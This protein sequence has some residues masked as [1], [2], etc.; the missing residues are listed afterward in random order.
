V[1]TNVP[2]ALRLVKVRFLGNAIVATEAN[3]SGF[4][5]G[6]YLLTNAA[7]SFEGRH[8]EFE[9]NWIDATQFASGGGFYASFGGS[10]AFRLEDVDLTGNDFTGP[11]AI[12]SG[13]AFDFY[14]GGSALPTVR[15]MRVLANGV[16]SGSG[17][18]LVRV[19][20]PSAAAISDLLV[21]DGAGYGLYLDVQCLTCSAVAGNLTVTGH[22]GSGLTLGENNGSLRVENSIVWNN[23]T[24]SG[25]NLNVAFGTPDL[26]PENLVGVDPLF[27]DEAG[28]DYRPGPLS[29]AIDAGDQTFASVGPWDAGHGARVLGLDVDLGALERGA[30][31]SDDFEH[32]DAWAWSASAP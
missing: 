17:Q 2:A 24:S 1:E 21:A 32:G 8:L 20:E 14:L 18:A 23:A 25:S 31:F 22:P 10:G 29:P 9:G 15:R 4:G 26:S 30:V 27:A 12:T 7:T 13:A 28:G 3:R 6:A 11:A 16:S 19:V 5:G